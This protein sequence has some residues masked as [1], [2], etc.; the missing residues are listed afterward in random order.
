MQSKFNIKSNIKN[1]QVFF[2]YDYLKVVKKYNSKNNYFI[3][4]KNIFQKFIENKIKIKNLKIISSNET[5]KEYKYTTNLLNY[6][7]RQKINNKMKIILIGGGSMQDLVS[8]VCSIYHRGIDWIFL[9]TTLLSQADSCIGGKNSINLLHFKNLVGNFYPPVKIYISKKFLLNLPKKNLYD[10][11]GEIF[12]I[13][14]V[15]NKKKILFIEK[16]LQ[17]KISIDYL[18]K[19]SLLCKKYF[20]EK[21]EFDKN[22][23]KLL[24]FG[25]T[26]GHAIESYSN[27]KISH[28]QAVAIGCLYALWMSWKMK[29]I[30]LDQ[31]MFYKKILN[32]IIL[33]KNKINILKLSRFLLKDKKAEKNYVNFILVNKNCKMFIKKIKIDNKFFKLFNKFSY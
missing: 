5:T 12:H 33:K 31:L 28:G 16:F 21:D 32:K 17:K 13:L 2:F 23:R 6:F 29:Y 8:F 3:I 22:L 15:Y 14:A 25:H 9:P 27:Y 11:L 10:G 4:D 7:K 1:Y 26:F 18:I 19:Q 24:N 20:I 30:N